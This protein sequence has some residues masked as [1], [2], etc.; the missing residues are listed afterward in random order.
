MRTRLISFSAQVLDVIA[1]AYGR[2]TR[3]TMIILDCKKPI[4]REYKR[5][6]IFFTSGVGLRLILGRSQE[7]RF[8]YFW[9]GPRPPPNL[10]FG[11]PML[12][13]APQC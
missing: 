6:G 11:P 12:R 3:E 10:E 7:C 13:S 1:H 8:V 4:I 9:V 2:T 5:N